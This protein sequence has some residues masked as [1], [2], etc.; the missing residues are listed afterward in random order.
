MYIRL[1]AWTLLNE[2]QW[3][4][5]DASAND[6]PGKDAKLLASGQFMPKVQWPAADVAF[7]VCCEVERTLAETDL[8]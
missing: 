6:G 2:I 8:S 3:V 1:S 7:E 4:L 5:I